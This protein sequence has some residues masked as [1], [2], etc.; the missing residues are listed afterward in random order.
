M[1]TIRSSSDNDETTIEEIFWK[2]DSGTRTSRATH[3]GLPLL[4]VTP[5]LGLC[6]RR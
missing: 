1:E 5:G 3:L 4:R 6:K 2:Q